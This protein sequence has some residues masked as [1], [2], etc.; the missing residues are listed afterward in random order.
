M[1]E[2]RSIETWTSESWPERY[3]I[4][5]RIGRLSIEHMFRLVSV[6][7]RGF[8]RSLQEQQPAEE[9]RD[10]GAIGDP[11]DCPGASSPLRL[12]A[13]HGGGCAAENADQPQA[14]G[15][16]HAGRYGGTH[17]SVESFCASRFRVLLDFDLNKAVQ[18]SQ[19]KKIPPNTEDNDL[20]G[21]V[22]SPKKCGSAIPHPLILLGSRSGRLQHLRK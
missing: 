12:S 4:E 6:S 22:V 20:V 11:T 7:R 21:E 8:Y 19:K 1:P 13:H 5:N 17:T 15:A 3:R 2:N 14:S 10:G 16:D 9:E 18:P